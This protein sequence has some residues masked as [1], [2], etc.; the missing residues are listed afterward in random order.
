MSAELTPDEAGSQGGKPLDKLC[1]QLLQR[2]RDFPAEELQSLRDLLEPALARAKLAEPQIITVMSPVSRPARLRL[3][4]IVDGT[5]LDSFYHREWA[6]LSVG[7]TGVMY[8][9][10]RRSDGGDYA[11]EWSTAT[12]VPTDMLAMLPPVLAMA[13]LESDDG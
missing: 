9:V 6:E 7:D 3:D 1:R 13:M 4:V 8:L 2:W 12:S 10:Y 11:V 5:D